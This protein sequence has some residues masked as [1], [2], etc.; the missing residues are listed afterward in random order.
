[1]LRDDEVF[2]IFSKVALEDDMRLQVKLETEQQHRWAQ[3]SLLTGLPVTFLFKDPDDKLWS[4]EGICKNITTAIGIAFVIGVF[5]II[6]TPLSA[7][8]EE[9]D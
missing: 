7:D 1:M 8:P 9:E 5:I 2:E 6:D 3:E 4:A